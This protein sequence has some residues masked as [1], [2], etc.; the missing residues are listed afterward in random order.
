MSASKPPPSGF[1]FDD[2]ES[3]GSNSSGEEAQTKAPTIEP[4]VAPTLELKDEDNSLIDTQ[5]SIP[6]EAPKPNPRI[7]TISQV[8]KKVEKEKPASP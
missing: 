5:V 6:E 4:T 3:G 2:G 8:E 7:E 1:N